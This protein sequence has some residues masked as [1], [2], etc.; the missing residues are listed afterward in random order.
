MP[1]RIFRPLLA[2]ARFRDRVAA[3]LGAAVGISLTIVICGL[4]SGAG[5]G[6][7]FIVA[8]L[9]ASAVLAFAVPASHSSE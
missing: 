6:I 4:F 1:F 2:G 9:G 8:P 7:P 5:T 3:C